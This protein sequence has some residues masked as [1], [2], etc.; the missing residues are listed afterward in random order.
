MKFSGENKCGG[1]VARINNIILLIFGAGE[2]NI[3]L[4]ALFSN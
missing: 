3:K 4:P 2:A 1:Y